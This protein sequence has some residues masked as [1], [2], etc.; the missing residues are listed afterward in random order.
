MQVKVL[1]SIRNLRT[2]GD[3]QPTRDCPTQA[4]DTIYLKTR[5]QALIIIAESDGLRH[6]RRPHGTLTTSSSTI[7]KS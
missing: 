6:H 2:R 5:F 1:I 7:K 3:N 4:R